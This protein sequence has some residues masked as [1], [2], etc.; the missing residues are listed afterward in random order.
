MSLFR[1]KAYLPGSL[2]AEDKAVLLQIRPQPNF[3][4]APLPPF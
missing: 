1:I 3:L 4:A 2:T